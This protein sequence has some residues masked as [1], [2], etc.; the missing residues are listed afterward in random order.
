M[1]ISEFVSVGHIVSSAV[2]AFVITIALLLESLWFLMK[3]EGGQFQLKWIKLPRN[4]ILLW[5]GIYAVWILMKFIGGFVNSV[6]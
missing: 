2:I 5:I 6:I 3:Y 4:Y 1:V